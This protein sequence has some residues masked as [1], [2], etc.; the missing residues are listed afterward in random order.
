[1]EQNRIPT[2]ARTPQ[3][4][5]FAGGHTQQCTSR[6]APITV[7]IDHYQERL[8]FD[9]TDLAHYDVIIGIPWLRKHN[10]HI[11][12][13]MNQITMNMGNKVIVLETNHKNREKNRQVQTLSAVELRQAMKGEDQLYMLLTKEA[14]PSDI[15]QEIQSDDLTKVLQKYEDVFPEDL[16]DQLPPPRSVDHHIHLVPG[17][18]APSRPT[19]R[20]SYT[21]MQELRRQIDELCNKNLIRPSQSPYGAPILFVKKKDGSLR[22]CVDYRALNRITIKNKY[23]LPRIEELFDQLYQATIFSKIDLRSGYHQIR[24]APEDTHKTAFRT[25]YGHFEFLVL[26]FGLTN[27]PATFMTLMNDIFRP[28]LDKCVVVYLDDILVFSR[29]HEEHLQHL[30]Q[31]LDIL[32]ENKLYAKRSKCEFLRTEVEFLGHIVSAK[33]LCAD[34]K[35]IQ[36]L[37]EWPQPNNVPEHQSFLGLANYY[38]KFVPNHADICVPLT[39]L[40]HKNQPFVWSPE[41]QLAFE[42]LKKALTTNPVLRLPNPDLPF[43]VTTDASDF[44][45]GAVLSQTHTN[46]NHPV[47][48]E[49]RKLYQAERNYA[50][51]E[52]ELLA[53]VHALKTWRVY[54]SGSRFVVFSD[55]LSLRF[56][57]T[58]PTLSRRQARWLEFLEEFDFDIQYKSGKTNSVADALSRRPDLKSDQIGSDF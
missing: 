40:L 24:I 3:L 9:V 28:L 34:P 41:C 48:F 5:Q 12:W 8:E 51:H 1:M 36:T 57:R 58:Q 18:E 27:A 22:L 10:P 49:S 21:E 44:A 37:C 32:R 46:G 47:A 25:R 23:P 26:P 39:N 4:V 20:L 42:R 38:R 7:S 19:Y 56:I 45:V 35:K 2:A 13:R 50:T 14:N 30:Q 11:D 16:P 6:T 15:N 33:G 17:S 53:V 43:E 31:V 52:K 29:S 54:L 55:H